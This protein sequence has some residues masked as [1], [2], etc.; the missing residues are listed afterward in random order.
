M[1]YVDP[2]FLR[3]EI[4]IYRTQLHW[5]VFII[6]IAVTVIFLA[7]FVLTVAKTGYRHLELLLLIPAV[8]FILNAFITR[9]SSEFAVTNKRVIMK[10]GVIQTSSLEILLNKVEALAV[11]QTLL[12]KML[13]YGDI[14]I[15]GSG[16]TKELYKGIEDPLAFRKA[17]QEATPV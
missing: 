9:R 1:S 17:V 15:T 5:K 3:D 14:I 12:G 10:A 16:G 4:V 7:V 13:N 6:P 8:F 11:N 2:H